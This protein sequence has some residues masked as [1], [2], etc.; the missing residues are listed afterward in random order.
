MI[1]EIYTQGQEKELQQFL[2]KNN[3]QKKIILCDANTHGYCVPVWR[4]FFSKNYFDAI[5][6]VPQGEENKTL[7]TC[8]YLWQQMLE[9]NI[10]KQDVVVLVGGGVLLDMGGFCSSVFK[11]GIPMVYVPTTLLAMVDACYGGKTAV[12]FAGTKNIIGTYTPANAIYINTIFLQTLHDRILKSGF[13]E[14]IKH[15]LIS[16]EKMWDSV[17]VAFDFTS[18][19]QMKK[20]LLIKKEIVDSDLYDLDKRQTLNFGHSIGH[21]IE[22][23]S[24]TTNN[25]LLHGEAIMLGMLYELKLSEYLL[26]TKHDIR[27]KL[28][29]IREKLFPA[30]TMH[31][32]F[33]NLY[34]FLVQDKKNDGT[35][36]MSLLKKVGECI[37]KVNVS[38]NDLK[39]IL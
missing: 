16:D 2:E 31:Y 23:Y 35:L 11:R 13:A 12:D 29:E 30:L 27:E 4:N 14:M 38:I 10:T 1:T 9:N 8:E 34:P 18:T 21:A 36:R 6:I 25:A 32:S 39:A 7:A 3:F 17:H 24:L 26:N 19:V 37:V 20:S 33:E 5:I 22:S 15:W 28:T